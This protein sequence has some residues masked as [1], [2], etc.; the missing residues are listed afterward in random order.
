MDR[1]RSG[2][3]AVVLSCLI[4][5]GT[6][7]IRAEPSVGTIPGAFDVSLNGSA[8]YSIPLRVAPGT[9]GT[10]PKITLLYD[11]QAGNGSLGAGWTISGFSTI[12]R[13]PK[14]RRVDGL[15]QGVQLDDTDP[16]YLDGQRLIPVS[17]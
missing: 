1:S 10:E 8:S 15:S 9:A 13:G 7:G 12:A 4:S 16:L 14:T 2:L 11:S 17:T 3:V 6:A 5:C